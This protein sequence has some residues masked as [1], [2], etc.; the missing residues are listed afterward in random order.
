[1]TLHSDTPLV[2]STVTTGPARDMINEWERLRRRPATLR[3]VNSWPFLPR[4]VSDLDEVLELAGFGRA[5]DDIEGDQLLWHLVRE[6][7]HD[8]I[9]A[10][11]V[12]HRILPPLMAMAKRRGRVVQGGAHTAMVDVLATAW[13]VI[14]QYPHQ[15]RLHKVAANL[16]RDIEYNAFVRHHR[17]RHVD[18][19]QV[20]DEI[21]YQLV[22]DS[23]ESYDGLMHVLQDAQEMG[24]D[25]RHITLLREFSKGQRNEDVAEI[26]GI[27][28]RT[29][30]NYK[31]SAII[32]IQEA[33]E[34]VTKV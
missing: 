11:I 20:G 23:A 25:E 26:M 22:E 14:R 6:G 27:S 17:L 5:I 10:R 34:S 4:R 32:A 19:R 18:E 1:M 15:R 33:Y 3:H 28:S 2:W 31:R 7:E 24:V 13:F 21:L 9:A 16:V 30:R 8:D 29:V 12:L